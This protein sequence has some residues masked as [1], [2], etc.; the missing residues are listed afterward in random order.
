MLNIMH[1]A[2]FAVCYLL[3][4]EPSASLPD[5]SPRKVEYREEAAVELD[6]IVNGFI[7]IVLDKVRVFCRM[8]SFF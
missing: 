7:D 1:Q 8:R 4:D 2:R 3:K 5:S 6:E